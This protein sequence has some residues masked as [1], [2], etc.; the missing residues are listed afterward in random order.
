MLGFEKGRRR[1]RDEALRWG[2]WATG[3]LMTTGMPDGAGAPVIRLGASS[4]ERIWVVF[5]QNP[6]S[7]MRRTMPRRWFGVPK[8]T[9]LPDSPTRAASRYRRG[10][11]CESRSGEEDRGAYRVVTIGWSW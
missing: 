4:P 5:G 9:T 1:P 7:A 10:R 3:A 6:A 11:W 8:V 2:H